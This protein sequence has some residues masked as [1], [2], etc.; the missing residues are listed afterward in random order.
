MYT[1]DRKLL[2]QIGVGAMFGAA[3]WSAYAVAEFIFSSIVFRYSRPYAVFT[4]WH[5]APTAYLILGYLVCGLL[6]GALVGLVVARLRK[7]DGSRDV[8]GL[9]ESGVGLVL[10]LALLGNLLSRRDLRFGGWDQLVLGLTF[11]VLLVA[12]MRSPFWRDRLGWLPNP[13]ILSTLWLGIGFVYALKRYRVA[14]QFGARLDLAAY[15][16]IGGLLLLALGALFIGQRLR[17]RPSGAQWPTRINVLSCSAAALLLAVCVVLQFDTASAVAESGGAASPRPN[18]VVIV[19]DTVRADHLSLQGYQRD[20]TP[21]LKALAKESVVYTNTFSASDITLTSHASLFTGMYPSWHGAYAEQPAAV[22][23]HEISAKYPT[24]AELLQRSGYETIGVAA[25]LYLRADFGLER[26]FREFRI[27][28][29]VP[30]FGDESRYMLRYGMRRVLSYVVDTAQ[31]DRLYAF[32]EDVDRELFATLNQRARPS[33]PF[34]AF[35]NYMDAHFPYVPPAPYSAQYPGRRPRF[36]QDDL[37]SEMEVIYHGG[38]E[39]PQYRSHCESQYDGGIAYE[40]A[41]IGKIVD[42]L[43]RHNAYDNTMIV[44]TSDHGEGFG[45]KNRVGHANSPYQNLV[46]V[47]LLIKYP[48]A[49]RRGVEAQPVSL[50]DVAP[51]ALATLNIP[52]PATMQGVTLAGGAPA[53]RQIFIE[54]FQNP[55]MNSPDCPIGCITKVIVEWPMKFIKNLTSGKPEFFDLSADPHEEHNLFAT[56]QDRAAAIRGRLDEWAKDLPQQKSAPKLVNPGISD[57]LRG[58]GYTQK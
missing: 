26:G 5:W 45:E 40:D 32:G 28:R 20:T 49:S 41:Q 10:V 25:N 33:D 35:V 56:Q 50:I 16:V 2:P 27:P 12:A 51:T 48:H 22:Y 7:S 37:E 29:P 34:F 42:W 55:V 38:G 11:A 18:L 47:G 4:A 52:A 39:P 43:K 13:W 58:N 23:G 30:M 3:A 54:T 44:V 21:N 24:L 8:S 9:L 14:T 46:H 17:R 31:F 1:N 19:M 15:T 6:S 57:T 36:T 53:N